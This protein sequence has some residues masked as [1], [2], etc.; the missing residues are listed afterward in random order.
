MYL[1]KEKKFS[2]VSLMSLNKKLLMRPDE[3]SFNYVNSTFPLKN[4]SLAWVKKFKLNNN[5]SVAVERIK[6]DKNY[7]IWQWTALVWSKLVCV[8]FINNLHISK[9]IIAKSATRI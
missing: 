6:N 2:K 8:N 3:N 4:K 9:N 1:E 5:F 7:Y